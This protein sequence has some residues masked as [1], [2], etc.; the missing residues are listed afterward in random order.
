MFNGIMSTEPIER[1]VPESGAS[2]LEA[3]IG[4]D[5]PFGSSIITQLVII[6]T[7]KFANHLARIS[8]LMN[9]RYNLQI[10]TDEGMPNRKEDQSTKSTA[11]VRSGFELL[12]VEPPSM[13][14]GNISPKD[15][16]VVLKKLNEKR[17]ELQVPVY[18]P[19][20]TH[21]IGARST[22]V[23]KVASSVPLSTSSGAARSTS[24]STE[25]S[26]TS[27]HSMA[28]P[29]PTAPTTS[30]PVST[31]ASAPASVPAGS[32]MNKSKLKTKSSVDET[33]QQQCVEDGEENR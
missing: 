28:I 29:L 12:G 19:E 4:T 32:P 26:A 27:S 15:L 5:Q 14:F 18:G 25:R 9:N 13:I 16:V 20:A 17:E 2:Q 7:G 23:R 6:K 22:F 21:F 3:T 8:S 31:F 33:E 30:A 1:L 11:L 24:S 10:L